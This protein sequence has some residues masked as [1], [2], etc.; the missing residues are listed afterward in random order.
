MSG[1][2][3]DLIPTLDSG[4]IYFQLY[5]ELRVMLNAGRKGQC[6]VRLHHECCCVHI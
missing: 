6:A 5:K 3:A 2:S 1:L 4:W